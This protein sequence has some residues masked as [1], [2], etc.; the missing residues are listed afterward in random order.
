MNFTC[1]IDSQPLSTDHIAAEKEEEE[2]E[3][4]ENQRLYNETRL[5]KLLNH[6]HM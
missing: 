4:N 6:S 3:F 1:K 5:E 2:L